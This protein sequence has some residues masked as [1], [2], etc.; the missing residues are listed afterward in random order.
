VPRKLKKAIKR[1]LAEPDYRLRGKNRKRFLRWL[2]RNRTA[3]GMPPIR[4]MPD[5]R[6]SLF[7]FV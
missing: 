1:W 5:G 6:V 3:G 7:D 2:N 4:R